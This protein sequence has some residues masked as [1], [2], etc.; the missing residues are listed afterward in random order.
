LLCAYKDNELQ[1]TGSSYDTF[2]CEYNA[3]TAVKDIPE[4]KSSSKKFIQDHQL[5][6]QSEGKTYNVLGVEVGKY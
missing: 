5:L 3:T 6:I 4:P 2:G 1:Y